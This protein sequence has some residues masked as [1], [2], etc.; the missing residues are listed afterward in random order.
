M[1]AL[2]QQLA[3]Y[4]TGFWGELTSIGLI[5]KRGG[6]VVGKGGRGSGGKDWARGRRPPKINFH[7][8]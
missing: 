1:L 5:G 4:D 3:K 6:G 2:G 8:Y 7:E